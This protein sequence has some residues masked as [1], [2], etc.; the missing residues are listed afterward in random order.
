MDNKQKINY[1]DKDTM[2][3][4]ILENENTKK[5]DIKIYNDEKRKPYVIIECEMTRP[6]QDN[7]KVPVKIISWNKDIIESAKKGEFNL[8]KHY[9]VH[10]KWQ[11]KEWTPTNKN[12]RILNSLVV[13]FKEDFEECNNLEILKNANSKT[14]L[15]ISGVII[16]KAYQCSTKKGFVYSKIPFRIT[17]NNENIIVNLCIREQKQLEPLLK[18][19]NSENENNVIFDITGTLLNRDKENNTANIWIDSNTRNIDFG[20]GKIQIVPSFALSYDAKPENIIKWHPKMKDKYNQLDKEK[21]IENNEE[22]SAE[23]D[24]IENLEKKTKDS[25]NDI[26]L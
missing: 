8:L 7:S 21:E 3:V 18:V 16:G 2:I 15:A 1:N 14:H 19:S 22:L 17:R 10:G 11:T 24:F 12:T 5:A 6:L 25:S 9:R 26:S 13:N 20:D 23:D 4:D